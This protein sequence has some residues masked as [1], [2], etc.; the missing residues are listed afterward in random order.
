MSG[1]TLKNKL[2]LAV[3]DKALEYLREVQQKHSKSKNI[4]YSELKLQ[5]Y[6][7]SHRSGTINEKARLFQIR[8]R[9]LQLKANFKTGQ[10]NIMCTLCEAEEES[11]THLLSCKALSSYSVISSDSTPVYEDIYS[12]DANK[13]EAMGWI[14]MERFDLWKEKQ[15]N[16]DAHNIVNSII[17]SIIGAAAGLTSSSGF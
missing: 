3:T 1:N 9:M 5:E 10:E 2:K 14:L 12:E 13:V 11:Q 17:S 15:N 4:Q 6:L 7:R 8:S 16:P